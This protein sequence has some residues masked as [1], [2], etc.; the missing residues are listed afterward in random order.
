[1]YMLTQPILQRVCW[2]AASTCAP[3]PPHIIV[4]CEHRTVRVFF[5][6]Q[7]MWKSCN[8]KSG[9]DPVCWTTSCPTAFSRYKTLWVN[10]MNLSSWC[11]KMPIPTW[12]RVQTNGT[13]DA[14][15]SCTQSGLTAKK[16][17]HIQTFKKGPPIH[18]GWQSAGICITV[19]EAD[20]GLCINGTPV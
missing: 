14:Q 12:P 7:E 8:N 4:Q 19:V 17:S 3:M 1:M 18:N 13:D 10:S 5:N 16:F 6:S 9:Q 15:T 2:A 20:N 11:T